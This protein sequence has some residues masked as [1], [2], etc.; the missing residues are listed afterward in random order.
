MNDPQKPKLLLIWQNVP[1]E[2]KLHVIERGTPQAKLARA[3]NEYYI[4]GDDL[5]DDHP[6]YA[7]SEWLRS[8]EGRESEIEMQKGESLRGRFSEIVVCGFFL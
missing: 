3:S 5:E 2:T 4:N 8:D 6:I 7:L 1:E